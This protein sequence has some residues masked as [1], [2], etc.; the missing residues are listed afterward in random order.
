MFRDTGKSSSGLDIWQWKRQ[1]WHH[2]LVSGLWLT[3]HCPSNCKDQHSL[4]YIVWNF[5][6]DWLPVLETMTDVLSTRV[7]FWLHLLLLCGR[8]K[9]IFPYCKRLFYAHMP[10][11]PKPELEV[12]WYDVISQTSRTNV[13][14]LFS[15]IRR[16]IWTK[17][18]TQLKI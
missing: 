5:H 13:G 3:T 7:H 10:T 4:S 17:F 18:R 15:S 8:H 12:N 9:W 11:W 1:Y 14:G 6:L 16:D 2:W